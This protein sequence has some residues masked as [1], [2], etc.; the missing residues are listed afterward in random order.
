[1]NQKKY[2]FRNAWLTLEKCECE[3]AF[4]WGLFLITFRPT[5]NFA[6]KMSELTTVF[7]YIWVKKLLD[8]FHHFTT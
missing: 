3:D 5:K 7:V 4:G 2:I 6:L 1:M 8:M